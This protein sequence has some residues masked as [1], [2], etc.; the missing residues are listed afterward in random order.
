[1]NSLEKFRVEYCHQESVEDLELLF[2][3]VNA[4]AWFRES[5]QY[6]RELLASIVVLRNKV[7]G[8]SK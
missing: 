3:W 8:S 7:N 4:N 6:F 1:M 5:K 2:A